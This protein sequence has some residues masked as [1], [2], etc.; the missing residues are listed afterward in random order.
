[1]RVLQKFY[2]SNKIT[3]IKFHSTVYV[4]SRQ[5]VFFIIIL[6]KVSKFKQYFKYLYDFLREKFRSFQSNI[7]LQMNYKK[8][9]IL[10]QLKSIKKIS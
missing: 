2:L 1:M 9:I 8:K 10:I 4:L 7:S 6:K 3:R 5:I